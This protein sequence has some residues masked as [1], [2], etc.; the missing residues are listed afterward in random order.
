MSAGVE[1]LTAASAPSV[2]CTRSWP[3]TMG[4]MAFADFL[5]R[6]RR[7][8]HLIALLVMAWLTHGM[9]PPQGSGY[10]TFTMINGYR[11]AYGPEWVGALVAML[12]SVYFMF[13]GFYLVRGGVPRD[14]HNGV[15]QI[16]AATRMSKLAYLAS[17]AFSNFLVLGSMMG[18]AMLVALAS[19]QLLGEDRRIDLLASWTPFLL[20]T[21]PV[22]LFIS[23]AAVCFDCLPV[24]RRGIGNVAWFFLLT[25]VLSGSAM[26]SASDGRA[27]MDLIGGRAVADRAFIDMQRRFPAVRSEDRSLSMGVNVSPEW[28]GK[29]AQTFPWRGMQWSGAFLM[30]RLFWC[31]VAVALLFGASAVFDRFER[32]SIAHAPRR[33]SL[34]GR[35]ERLLHGLAPSTAPAVVRASSLTVAP[36]TFAFVNLLGAE[37]VLLLKALPLWWYLGAAGFVIAGIFAPPAH[38][39]SGWLPVASFWPVFAWSTLGTREKQFDTAGIFFSVARPVLRMLPASWIA[40]AL[41]MLAL[42]STAML[43]LALAGHTPV[44]AGWV[45]AAFTVPALALALGVWTGSSKFFEVLY[46]FLWYIGPMHHLA[47]FDYTG[48]TTSRSA[49]L[50]VVYIAATLLLFIAAWVGRIRQVR[51]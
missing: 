21:G 20:L 10:R 13:V 11:P 28:K 48:V 40:G 41:L 12:T 7:P 29:Q 4:S 31:G 6:T 25:L 5:E 30:V 45:L 3:A 50:W 46:L 34:F 44:V 43:R 37:V 27:V 35:F 47:E 33:A 23:C 19:Q 38:L 2:P 24:L 9:L 22:A 49:T 14:A 26:E 51:S 39:M 36:R 32:G 1:F 8:G 15:G 42:G 16:L 17:K 18:V